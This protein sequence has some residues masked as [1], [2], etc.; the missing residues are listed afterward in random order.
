[1]VRQRHTLS[2]CVCVFASM[3]VRACVRACVRECVSGGMMH[4]GRRTEEG[5][6]QK[7]KERV[8]E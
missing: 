6:T 7:E 2:V 3:Y 4:G 5:G 1:M 8:Q